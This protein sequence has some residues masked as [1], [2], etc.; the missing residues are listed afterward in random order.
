MSNPTDAV[1]R[2]A[3][4]STAPASVDDQNEAARLFSLSIMIAGTRCLLTYIVFPWVLPLLGIARG[5]GPAIGIAVGVLAI[6]F[7]VLSIRRFATSKHAWRK[8]VIALNCAVIVGLLV[9]IT[10]DIAEL[11]G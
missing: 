9:L 3:P 2:P 6:V 10:T 1:T 5:I 4:P 11:V 7:N 8:P